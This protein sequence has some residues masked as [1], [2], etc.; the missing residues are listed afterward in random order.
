M[1]AM[2]KTEKSRYFDNAL[3]CRH[4]IRQGDSKALNRPC[5]SVMRH[6]VKLL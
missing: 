2:L 5:A 1:A 4:E 3:T 6:F